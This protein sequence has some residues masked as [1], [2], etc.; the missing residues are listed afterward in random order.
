MK[1]VCVFVD[2]ESFRH[3]IEKLFPGDFDTNEYLPK[4]A[5]WAA[6]FD[7]AVGEASGGE[8]ERFRAYWYVIDMVDF[9]PFK[10]PRVHR[11]PDSLKVVLRKHQPNREQLDKLDGDAL[12]DAMRQMADELTD[13]RNAFQS[14]FNGWKVIQ[15][16]ISINHRAVEFRRAGAISYNLFKKSLGQ[17]KA[18]DVKL[19]ADLIVLRDIY[20]SAL[21]V[22]GDQDYVPAVQVV[23]DAGKEVINV[24]FLKPDGQVLPGG[25]RR[26]NQMTDSS[27]EV[28]H[29][30]LKTF[31]R[32]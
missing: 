21:I 28:Q 24:S 31:L 9:Y 8:A 1:R 23:K 30:K 22:S 11:D 3:S 25:A 6:F 5:G 32:L 20:D 27:V 7:W 16:G 29:D 4:R 13:R 14:R 2:G 15:D 17:E 26:L 12:L 19:A 10:L 18:V